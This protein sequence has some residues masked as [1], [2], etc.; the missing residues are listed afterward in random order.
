MQ[1]SC[2][3]CLLSKL[4]RTKHL[5]HLQSEESIGLPGSEDI[6]DSGPF[7]VTHRCTHHPSKT[8]MMLYKFKL[9]KHSRH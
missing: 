6:E 2:H 4:Y 8:V 1:K 7:K 3:R 9:K 5:L